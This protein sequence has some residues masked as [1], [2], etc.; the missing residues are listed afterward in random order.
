MGG[1]GRR[2]VGSGRELDG[3]GGV[4]LQESGWPRCRGEVGRVLV[5]AVDWV[6]GRRAGAP[7]LLRGGRGGS[8]L[9]RIEGA[10]APPPLELRS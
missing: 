8:S 5:A 6:T 10:T 7:E 1:P 4:L 2:G 9:P 3:G